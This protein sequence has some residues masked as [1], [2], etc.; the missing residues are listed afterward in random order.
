[1][2]AVNPTYNLWVK[3]AVILGKVAPQTFGVFLP[4]LPVV[5]FSEK[6]VQFTKNIQVIQLE[7]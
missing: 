7:S 2:L 5:S 4:L 3:S 1:M 6:R